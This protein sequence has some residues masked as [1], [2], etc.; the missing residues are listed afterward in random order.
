[1]AKLLLGFDVG[2]QSSKGVLISPEGE[3]AASVRCEHDIY[4]PRPG[5]AEQDA[6]AIWWGDFRK[7][8]KLLLAEPGVKASDIA[9]IGCSALSP[10][11]LPLDAKGAPLRRAVLYGIDT[12]NTEEVDFINREIGREK[13]L[14]ISGCEADYNSAG[15][16]ILWFKNKEPDLFNRTSKF[17]GAATYLTYRL[18]GRFVVDHVNGIGFNPLYN[19]HT[20]TWDDEICSFIGVKKSQ[21]PD[22]NDAF[23]IAGY[24]TGE[25]GADI[26]LPEGIPVITGTEDGAAELFSTGAELGDTALAYGSTMVVKTIVDRY[27]SASGLTTIPWPV[28]GYYGAGGA[29]ATAASIITWFKKQF[30]TEEVRAERLHGTDA[31]AALDTLAADIPAGSDNLI[32][33]PYFAGERTP[34]CDSEACGVIFGIGLHHT[35]A[36]LYR[37][38]LEGTAFSLLHNIDAMR[39]HNIP[40]NRFLSVGGG[41]KSKVWTQIVSDVTG[42]PQLCLPHAA[43]AAMGDA[44]LCGLGIGLFSD[45]SVLKSQW[46]SRDDAFEVL[47]NDNN[48]E[49]YKELYSVYRRLYENTKHLMHCLSEGSRRE[50]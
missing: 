19:I 10:C 41:A 21:L 22:I 40:V 28:R 29:T 34:I 47:P 50:L 4:R 6:E 32:A 46:V 16:K 24:L 44:Y 38:F 5:W 30:G 48:T 17:A 15:A 9:G 27:P 36:H 49:K 25:A 7:T 45:S 12:R 2:T 37:S 8:V 26:G 3:I 31:Y 11:M 43:G 35:R 23:H 42:V 1:M 13:L 20:K 39:E 18:T 14:S 33:L